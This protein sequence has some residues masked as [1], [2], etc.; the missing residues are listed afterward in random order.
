MG[1]IPLDERGGVSAQ[2]LTG[3]AGGGPRCELR[4]YRDDWVLLFWYA[5]TSGEA[6]RTLMLAEFDD[7]RVLRVR[8]YLFTPD[9]IA[10]VCRELNVPHRVN[11][12]RFWHDGQ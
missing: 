1:P 8:N 12:Y 3:Y 11:G 7:D 4:V 2:H 6:V 10:E 5:H 9:V